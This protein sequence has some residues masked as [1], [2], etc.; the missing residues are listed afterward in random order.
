MTRHH[1]RRGACYTRDRA[2]VTTGMP[3]EEEKVY[4]TECMLNLYQVDFETFQGAI[5]RFGYKVDLNDEH[6]KEI[7]KEIKC[8]FKAMAED[9]SS[10]F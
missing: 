9:R 6:M 3:V 10:P 2:P 7:S 5:K 8:D 1:S 4:L